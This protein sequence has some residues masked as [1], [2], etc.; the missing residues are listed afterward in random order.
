MKTVALIGRPNV[1]KSSLFNVLTASRDALVS[2]TPGLTRDRNYAKIKIND[3]K[4]III[5]TGG[6]EDTKSNSIT[7]KI[8]EQTNLAIDECDIIFFIVDG[9]FGRHHYDDEIVHNLRKKNKNILLI[10][11]KT[12]SLNH[13][14]VLAEFQSYGFKDRVCISASHRIGTN[15]LNE[16]LLAH[17]EPHQNIDNSI[18][19]I[20]KI[21][22]LGKPNV[23]KSTLINA[24]I[25]EE[26]FISYDEPGTTRDSIAVDYYYE[27]KKISLIDTAG[28]RR[29]GK[30]VD[31]IEKFS[32]LKSLL[33]IEQ[34]NLSVLVIDSSDGLTSQ[35]LQ[36]MSY[37]IDLGRPFILAV[38]KCD[39]LDTYG[40][41]LLKDTLEKKIHFFSNFE[42]VY[43]SALKKIGLKNIFKSSMRAYNSS[44]KKIKTSEL[45][46]FLN[47]IQNA[48]QPP[49]YKG[50][51]PKLKYAHQGAICPPTII[52]HG[53]HLDGV[54]KD[55]LRYIETTLIKT[56]NLVGTPLKIELVEGKNPYHEKLDK[57]KKVGL[58]TRR[59][60][61]N[62]KR[63]QIKNKKRS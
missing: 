53:N 48:H 49:I 50:I 25:G 4:F 47:E 63:S 27:D 11:N 30:V 26:R 57:I 7:H 55:Y 51:R 52:I 61:I 3:S 14:L 13:D 41:K 9:R 33:A 5:D 18:D 12:E 23:G 40:K 15:L 31:K 16:Y 60:E 34:S 21:S 58:V 20:L 28:I 38:N 10:I 35:D 56:F 17:S 2:D 24:I 43:I 6:I 42:I 62:L 59:R 8:V 32:L 37:I 19:D 39:I 45:N 22:I 46:N 44:R 36:I 54:K 1:G 29:K